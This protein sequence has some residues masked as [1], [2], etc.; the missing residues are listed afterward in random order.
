MSKEYKRHKKIY[1]SGAVSNKD[2]KKVLENKALFLVAE[3]KLKAQGYEVV[4][5]CTL[6]HTN[7]VTWTGYMRVDLKELKKCDII[8][9]L[10]GW[11]N[12]KGAG[13]EYDYACRHDIEVIYECAYKEWV[14]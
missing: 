11:F 5:P 8:F 14:V 4:N 12:S 13:I 6:D 10:R 2:P 9:M 1:I 7:S 3:E